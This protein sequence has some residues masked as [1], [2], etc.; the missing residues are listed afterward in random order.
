MKKPPF[1]SRPLHRFGCFL[2]GLC[3]LTACVEAPLRPVPP[4]QKAT[5]RP[6]RPPPAAPISPWQRLPD[7][8]S[9]NLLPSWGALQQSCRVLRHKAGWKNVCLRADRLIRPNNAQIRTF[10]EAEFI[11]RQLFNPDGSG[12]GLV[13]GY[14]EPKLKGSYTR[15]ARFRYPLYAVPEAWANDNLSYS[16]ATQ[17]RYYNRAEIEAGLTDMRGRELFWVENEVDLYWLC[18]NPP[19]NLSCSL[20]S[21]G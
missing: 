18:R 5:M 9:I 12:Q 1:L 17:R 2:C 11:P 6:L 8:N 13:T 20:D 4:P 14:Y 7:W 16:L 21:I 15:T 19:L 10:F 3:L